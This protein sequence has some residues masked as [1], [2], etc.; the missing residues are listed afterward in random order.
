MQGIETGPISDDHYQ[1][2]TSVFIDDIETSYQML[3]EKIR[4]VLP[5]APFSAN[6]ETSVPSGVYHVK[7]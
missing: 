1:T 5:Y 3:G 6:L 4:K 2:G 7:N